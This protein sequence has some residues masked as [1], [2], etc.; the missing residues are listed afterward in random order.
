MT[1]FLVAQATD[2]ARRIAGDD[3]KRFD[4][5]KDDRPRPDDRSF[6]DRYARQYARIEADPNIAAYAYALGRSWAVQMA[7]SPE[8]HERQFLSAL[9]GVNGNSVRIHQH[10]IPRD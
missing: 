2:N 7:G 10:D 1:D 9:R 3:C 6:P 8:R 5:I 4:V